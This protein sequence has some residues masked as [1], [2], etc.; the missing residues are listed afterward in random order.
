MEPAAL[1]STRNYK[2]TL[3]R[4]NYPPN[5]YVALYWIPLSFRFLLFSHR[6]WQSTSLSYTAYFTMLTEAVRLAL[7]SV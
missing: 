3:L 5:L 2:L 4:A 7:I 6:F 1:H